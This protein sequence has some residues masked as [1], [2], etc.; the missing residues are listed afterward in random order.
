VLPIGDD[1]LDHAA[2]GCY[3]FIN[4]R[5]FLIDECSPS[6]VSRSTNI[7]STLLQVDEK[8]VAPARAGDFFKATIF[9]LAG[10]DLAT[11]KLK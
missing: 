11:H 6:V 9:I 10:F 7:R 1:T 2:R 5:M 4:F 8:S 3:V